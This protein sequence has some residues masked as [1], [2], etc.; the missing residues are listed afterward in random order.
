MKKCISVALGA[1]LALGVFSGVGVSPAK[2][3]QAEAAVTASAPTF[4][5]NN[6]AL[7]FSALSDVHV[8]Y[9]NDSDM[10]RRALKISKSFA[11]N[12]IDA[13]LFSGD[14]TQ[15]GTQAQAKEFLSILEEEFDLTK[16]PAIITN[17]NHDTFMD[18]PMSAEE[19][20]YVLSEKVYMHE[21][22]DVDYTK[23]NRHVVVNG[24]HFLS[25]E[26][27][28]YN[29]KFRN[30]L[31]EES[32][33]WLKAQLDKITASDPDKYVFVSCH[34]PVPDTVYGSM[35]DTYTGQWGSSPE[36]GEILNGYPQVVFFSGHT[37]RLVNDER[38]INQSTFTQI[39][40]P[41]TCDG[42]VDTDA[43]G[44]G[45]YEGL[46][47]YGEVEN[48]RT[49]SQ[50]HLVEVDGKGNVRITR[51]DFK[52]NAKIKDYW[53]LDSCKAD[54]SHLNRYTKELRAA[55]NTAPFFAD[56]AK[57][58]AE[59][60]AEREIKITYPAAQ[61]DDM[62]YSYKLRVLDEAGKEKVS[63]NLLAPWYNFP[64]L[65]TMPQSFVW[66]AECKVVYPYTVE[67]VAYDSYGKTSE[68]LVTVVR[69]TS[70]EDKAAGEALN[71]R[72]LA[73]T[74]KVLSAEDGDEIE[75]IR[76]EYSAFND[77]AKSCCT[78]YGDFCVAES[79][80]YNDFRLPKDAASYAPTKE[81]SYSLAS[82]ASTGNAAKSEYTGLKLSWENSTKNNNV[83]LLSSYRL[84][85]LHLNFANLEFKSDNRKLA[86]L[87]SDTVK[88]RY[89][90]G[91][92]L[93]LYIDFNE[94]T[95]YANEGV[96]AQSDLL[97]YENLCAV[98]FS[99]RFTAADDGALALEVAVKNKKQTFQIPASLLAGLTNLKAEGNCY[100]SLSPWEK[101]T[102]AYIDV[103]SLHG[104]QSE[105]FDMPAPDD[106][107]EDASSGG[108]KSA[109][110]APMAVIG[111]IGLS[112][113]CAVVFAKNKKEN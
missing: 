40:T 46:G 85:R 86:I 1:V 72:M 32:K 74:G 94:G 30:Y 111:A 97:L 16:T 56:N 63:Y 78:A 39:T 53:Y 43:F 55:Q 23:G 99:M 77:L 110:G 47:L 59:A 9:S 87:L 105:C 60:V 96:L 38:A 34:C 22:P 27:K 102:T 3:I 29:D 84:N 26:M 66:N 12:G 20:A 41:S 67:I 44:G 14:Q 11:P 73:V 93:L 10:L 28:S 13:L 112:V 5:E 107:K 19:W 79:K 83:G 35:S 24:Y 80:Y 95:L 108:C 25:V 52:R 61:D 15:N 64:D 71:R 98:P 101:Q 37:H 75:A 68:P 89:A 18:M 109:I 50:G 92:N 76:S 82:K 48:A 31:T 69:D 65:S 54:G 4:D 21:E 2:S 8:G 100:V 49:Y 58:K 36:L 6:I 51:I 33:T 81:N 103:V 7:T 104:G 88:D 17:G 106:G 42:G 62:V 57:I 45:L 70:E 91:K 113:V 90:D